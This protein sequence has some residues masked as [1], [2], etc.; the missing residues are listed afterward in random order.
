MEPMFNVLQGK[1]GIIYHLSVFMAKEAMQKKMRC[2]LSLQNISVVK[3]KVPEKEVEKEKRKYNETLVGKV[4]LQ[5]Y[6]V[7]FIYMYYLTLVRFLGR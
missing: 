3:Q 2:L 5:C 6:E 4:C 7:W 1:W